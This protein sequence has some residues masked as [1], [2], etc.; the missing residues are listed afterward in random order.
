M[1]RPIESVAVLTHDHPRCNGVAMHATTS[2]L[3]DWEAGRLPTQHCG[4]CG[5]AILPHE[6]ERGEPRVPRY[7][8]P[9]MP[10]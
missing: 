1:P 8:A 6:V 10:S 7:R 2:W 3:T 9:R 5:R 4:A